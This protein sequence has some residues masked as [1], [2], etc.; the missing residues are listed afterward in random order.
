MT[1]GHSWRYTGCSTQVDGADAARKAAREMMRAGADGIKVIGTGGV[2]TKGVEPYSPQLTV[3]EMAAAIEECHK[4]GGKA[5]SHAQGNTGIKNSIKA[6]VDSIEHGIY[7][8]EESVQL[9]KENNVYFVPTLSALYWILQK[10]DHLPDYV[11]RKTREGEI[12][13]KNSFK[14]AK[15]AGI[16]ICMG[17]DSG[18]P[19]N[20]Y[21]NSPFELV[22]M[23]EHGMTPMEA[24]I[25]S[26]MNSA[27]LCNVD[28]TLGSITVGKRAHLAVF[29]GNPIE[30]INAIMNCIMTVKDGKIIYEN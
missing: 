7:L 28:K 5:C 24:M 9:M 23:V 18:T 19:N 17:T 12:P 21:D 10:P 1:G 26:T 22:L 20:G 8:D 6:G 2:M 15:E 29:E 3:E 13:H 4:A 14:M 30:D 27:E 11:V 16:K 25:A